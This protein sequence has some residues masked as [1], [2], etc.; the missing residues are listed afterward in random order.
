MSRRRSDGSTAPNDRGTISN[1]GARGACR[2]VLLALRRRLERGTATTIWDLQELT[3]LPLHEA[4]AAVRTL[5]IGKVVRIDD[6]PAD[7]FGA[8]IVL[9]PGEVGHLTQN[10]AA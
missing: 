6:D 1:F 2:I 5:E 4:F 3:G 7:P 9:L 10:R 8:V